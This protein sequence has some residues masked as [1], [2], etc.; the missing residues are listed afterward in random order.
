MKSL[1]NL[2]VWV[3][4]EKIR[5]IL[6]HIKTFKITYGNSKAMILFFNKMEKSVEEISML[7]EKK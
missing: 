4:V 2:A 1:R 7:E 6:N 5:K 3:V